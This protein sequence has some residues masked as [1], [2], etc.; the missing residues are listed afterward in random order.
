MR[1]PAIV[2]ALVVV[3]QGGTRLFAADPEV[4]DV[5]AQP[6]K[7]NAR[8]LIDA[9]ELLGAPLPRETRAEIEHYLNGHFCRCTGYWNILE[10]VADAA[11]KM[12]AANGQETSE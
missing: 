9:L 12:A 3:L 4:V 1:A 6:L 5:E 11:E 7:A 2:V 8:R 10:A